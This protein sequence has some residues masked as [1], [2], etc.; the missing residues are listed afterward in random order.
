MSDESTRTPP[1]AETPQAPRK[2]YETPKL[3]EYGDIAKL[4][5]TAGVTTSDGKGTRKSR[6]G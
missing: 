1:S 2:P 4:T 5:Q 6:I 3:V